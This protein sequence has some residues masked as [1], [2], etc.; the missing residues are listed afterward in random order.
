MPL[1][2]YFEFPCI[3]QIVSQVYVLVYESGHQYLHQYRAVLI[4]MYSQWVIYMCVCVCVCVCIA[5]G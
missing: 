3:R 2:L 4:T 1:L 5:V